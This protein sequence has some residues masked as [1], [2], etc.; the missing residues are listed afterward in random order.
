MTVYSDN[1]TLSAE[2]SFLGKKTINL[3]DE[4][5]QP[6]YFDESAL[7]KRTEIIFGNDIEYNT[8]ILKKGVDIW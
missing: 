6:S 7:Q 1:A 4:E 2:T 8:V 3:Y 5:S